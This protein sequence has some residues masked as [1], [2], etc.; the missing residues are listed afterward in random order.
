MAKE[1]TYEAELAACEGVR[2]FQ[3]FRKVEEPGKFTVYEEF[4]GGERGW[5]ETRYASDSICGYGGA[6]T[7]RV[8]DEKVKEFMDAIENGTI[9]EYYGLDKE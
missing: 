8:S 5:E 1:I 9:R 2:I 4:F 6:C 3:L 7:F